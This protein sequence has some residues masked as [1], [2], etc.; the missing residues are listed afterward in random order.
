MTNK[1]TL[2]NPDLRLL[3]LSSDSE[4]DVAPLEA[5]KNDITTT[6]TCSGSSNVQKKQKDCDPQQSCALAAN[7]ERIPNNNQNLAKQRVL[8]HYYIVESNQL[9]QRRENAGL[10]SN[11]LSPSTSGNR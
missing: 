5:N 1:T 9:A 6:A 8:H 10:D 3:G 2:R 7:D 4:A 11:V